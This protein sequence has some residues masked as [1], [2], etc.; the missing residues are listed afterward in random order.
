MATVQI[1]EYGA[2]VGGLGTGS[3]DGTL[4]TDKTSAG[5]AASHTL[6]ASTRSYTVKA[7]GGDIRIKVGVGVTASDASGSIRLADGE[8]YSE[9]LHLDGYASDTWIV[10]YIDA[11]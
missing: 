11:A 8:S 10:S 4:A 7:I 1:I 9:A 6:A 3:R 5:T 2:P